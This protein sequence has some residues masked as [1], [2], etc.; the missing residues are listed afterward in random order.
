MRRHWQREGVLVRFNIGWKRPPT[1]LPISS[2]RWASCKA[3]C[4]QRR[5]GALHPIG[6]RKKLNKGK[7][8]ICLSI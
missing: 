6:L 2:R 3:A 1:S 8:R 7:C 5:R 4:H